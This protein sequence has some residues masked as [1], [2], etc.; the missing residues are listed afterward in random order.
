MKW[1]KAIYGLWL[2]FALSCLATGLLIFRT[3]RS[4]KDH[5]EATDSAV[6][7]EIYAWNDEQDT[8]HALAEGF[9]AEH[10]DIRINMHYY[11]TTEQQQGYQIALN[12]NSPVDIIALGTPAGAAQLVDK[13]Q[14]AAL[15][16]LIASSSADFGGI[17]S[18][19]C[20]LQRSGKTYMLPYRGSAWV[21]Y[22]NKSIFDE[23]GIAYPQGDWTWEEYADLAARLSSPEKGWFGSLNYENQWWRVPARTAG[24]EDPAKEEDL[25][26]FAQAAQWCYDLT[27]I[28][29]A[30]APYTSLTSA[31]AENYIGRFLNGEAAM[32]YNGEWCLSSLNEHIRTDCP[33]FSYDVAPLPSW[34]KGEGYAIGT[35]AVLMLAEKSEH[36]QEAFAFLAYACGE[37]GARVLA[38]R[39]FLPAWNSEEIQQIFR[40]SME[41]PLNTDCFFPDEELSA[42]PATTEYTIAINL[43]QDSIWG[44]LTQETS[45]ETALDS[46]RSQL[47]E[48]LNSK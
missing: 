34:E 24:A 5:P 11:P 10:P 26:L 25:A 29:H 47:A 3:I 28:R 30:A 27:Y 6:T 23:M 39:H 18:I 37:A 42:F 4:S 14:V 22:Y 44:Y 12:S 7:L 16:D 38:S 32:M 2:L 45:L 19:I 40:D 20:A 31:D 36:P 1:K 15:D 33:D 21:V 43:L 35:N 41:Q 46:Y 9:M 8:F 17:E 48:R 13:G